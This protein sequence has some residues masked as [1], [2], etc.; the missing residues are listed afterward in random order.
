MSQ[1]FTKS[2]CNRS[3]RICTDAL[4]CLFA[5]NVVIFVVVIVVEI[6]G[7]GVDVAG[8]KERVLSVN[9]LLRTLDIEN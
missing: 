4:A 3:H 5:L 1:S 2:G 6:V 9:E 7:V 8:F